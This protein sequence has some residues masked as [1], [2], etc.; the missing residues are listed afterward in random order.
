VRNQYEE[1]QY[2]QSSL[3][4]NSS[5]VLSNYKNLIESDS[6]SIEANL[7]IIQSNCCYNNE[8]EI[9]EES[10]YSLLEPSFLTSLSTPPATPLTSQSKSSSSSLSSH[11]NEC[12]IGFPSDNDIFYVDCY[13]SNQ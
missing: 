4:S 12:V 13:N 5:A 7:E 9:E 11:D 2:L 8:I 3:Q 10:S 6:H 1:L